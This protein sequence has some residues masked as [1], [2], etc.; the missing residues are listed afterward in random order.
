MQWTAALNGMGQS[1][2][3]WMTASSIE[4]T[5]L[6]AA[7][8]GIWLLGR[9]H[10]SP[11]AGYWL[12]LLVLVKGAVPL[13]VPIPVASNWWPAANLDRATKELSVRPTAQVDTGRI[14]PTSDSPLMMTAAA[15]ASTK[16]GE[17]LAAD[18]GP[19]IG[20]EVPSGVALA[21]PAVSMLVWAAVVLLL[22]ASTVWQHVRLLRSLR[23]C[24][25]ANLSG[26]DLAEL[27]SRLG[28]RRA[29][30]ALT[31]PGL[32]APAVTGLLHPT[33]L[34]PERLAEQLTREQL[35][36][37]LLH[38]LAHVRRGDLWTAAGQRLLT[39]GL[40]FHPAAWLA[41]WI[42]DQFRECACDDLALTATHAPRR[43]CGEAFVAIL[44]RSRQLP[45][46]PLATLGMSRGML[47]AR[48][49]LVRL[50]DSKRT[51]SSGLT[52][53]AVVGLGLVVCLVLPRL[54]AND[55]PPTTDAIVTTG[56]EPG[57][58]QPVRATAAKM[59]RTILVKNAS[60]VQSLQVLWVQ[61][62]S[63]ISTAR[64]R[65]R[66][67][68]LA[69]GEYKDTLQQ[70]HE[71]QP[72][73]REEVIDVL[74][75]VDLAIRPQELRQVRDQLL[76]GQ[77]IV[78]QPVWKVVDIVKDG[79]KL[80]FD[81]EDGETVVFNGTMQVVASTKT[82]QASIYEGAPLWYDGPFQRKLAIPHFELLEARSS[83]SPPIGRRWVFADIYGRIMV[84]A[85]GE[86]DRMY[87]E[88]PSNHF[89]HDIFQYGYAIFRRSNLLF[90]LVRAEAHYRNDQTQAVNRVTISVI[91]EAEFNEPIPAE[92]FRVS[93]PANTAVWDRRNGL[94]LRAAERPVDDVLTLF[95][96]P[97]E[98]GK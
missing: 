4:L 16:L 70:R 69:C 47:L 23:H 79:D 55:G 28:L 8:A 98:P 30:P 92:A 78:D 2:L 45:L 49:R 95:D 15:S 32:G 35:D 19:S 12:F 71:L 97:D 67:M 87:R 51:V 91:E 37:V 84:D 64:I 83:S 56:H 94:K 17:S 25:S 5:I 60:D 20:L 74:N 41:S 73:T 53:P 66:Y 52:W 59:F 96:A 24:V 6:L 85:D 63:R 58:S 3:V 13:H 40:F 27:A 75:K 29:V 22:V 39:I 93:V 44:E 38:E 80:R 61:Q 18:S 81:W 9:R 34:M 88:N 31:C 65:L 89:Y 54:Q 43:A 72:K 42:I 76:E 1:W 46:Q 36:W 7:A 33:L 14:A 10:I 11:H 62:R 26:I 77:L 86:L 48:R 68:Y 82:R 50:I 21:W 90:P 57:R